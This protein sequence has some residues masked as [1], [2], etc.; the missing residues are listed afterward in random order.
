MKV[1]EIQG[2]FG[3]DRLTVAERPTPEPAVGQ[4]LLRMRAASLNYRDLLTALGKYNPRQT[5]PLIP[6]SDGVGEVV[7][8]GDGVTRFHVGE[9]VAPIFSQ[10]WLSGVPNKERVRATLGGPLDGT[11][12]EFMVLPESGLV[13]APAHLSDEEVATL[14]CAGV[15]AWNALVTQASIGPGSTVLVLGTGGVA[16]FALQFA[17]LLG[18]R[19]IVTS[20]SDSKLARARDLGAWKTI[21]YVSTPAWGKEVLGLTEGAGVDLVVESGGAGTL[22]QSMAAARFGGQISLIGNLAG[23]TAE[24]NI[25][26][27]FMKNLRLQG[28]L[29]G[30]RESF[31]AMNDAVV[32]HELRPVVDRV[33]PFEE[34]RQALQALGRGE[35]FGKICIRIET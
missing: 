32:A 2:G 16:L 19:A 33:Y 1:I 14:P 30:H 34:S 7:A 12:A 5:L 21:N 8:L 20:S 26:P 6:C 15:T 11:L 9:R 31:E 28:I 17:Q 23:G 29:V 4:V 24:L 35:H 3:L 18:A 25:I 13:R 27:L 10:R 22:G